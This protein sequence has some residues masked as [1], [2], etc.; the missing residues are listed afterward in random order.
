MASDS[1]KA[2]SL[3]RGHEERIRQLEERNEPDLPANL[4]KVVSEDSEATDSVS[5]TVEEASPGKWDQD[6]WDGTL[7]FG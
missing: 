1:A 7:E 5:R 2:A 4:V 3:I 6:T